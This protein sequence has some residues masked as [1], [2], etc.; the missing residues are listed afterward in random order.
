MK[1]AMAWLLP[2]LFV[3]LILAAQTSSF[4]AGITP[5]AEKVSHRLSYMKDV[6]GY[7]AQNHLPIEDPVQEAKVLDSAKSEAEKLGLDPT[8]VEPFIIAQIKAAKAVEYRYLADWLAQPETGWQ[9]RPLD[10]VRQDIA[11]LSKEILEQ[12]ARDLKSGR[13]TSDERSSFFKVVHE[14]N[15]KESDKQQLFSALLAIRLAK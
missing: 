8:T 6:A 11:R 5:L 10:K 12:L 15:L 14:P 13:F 7:K 2:L 3:S 4:A 9:P 1:Q